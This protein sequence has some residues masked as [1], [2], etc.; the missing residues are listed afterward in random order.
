MRVSVGYNISFLD[1]EGLLELDEGAGSLPKI[2]YLVNSLPRLI[3][4]QKVCT[5]HPYLIEGDCDVVGDLACLF[6][7]LCSSNIR[8]AIPCSAPRLHI[9]SRIYLIPQSFG[10]RGTFYDF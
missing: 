6:V 5:S 10:Q 9:S 3:L 2:L 8:A 7:V 1:Y 4:Y